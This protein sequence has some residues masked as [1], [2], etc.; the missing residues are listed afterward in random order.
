MN[1]IMMIAL[2]I[3]VLILVDQNNMDNNKVIYVVT[4]AV[5]IMNVLY[6]LQG[7]ATGV[8]N[9]LFAPKEKYPDRYIYKKTEQLCRDTETNLIDLQFEILDIEYQ[10]AEGRITR[11]RIWTLCIY[12]DFGHFYIRA[13]CFLRFFFRSFRTDR[14]IIA[15][16]RKGI[17]LIRNGVLI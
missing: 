8:Y 6:F 17:V 12:R 11:R 15:T 14:V 7:V 13:F 2:C 5:I 16:N 1:N 9:C 3:P 10:D 4:M